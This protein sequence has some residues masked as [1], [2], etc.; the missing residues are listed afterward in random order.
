MFAE[1]L[2]EFKV[3][4]LDQTFT[5]KID[6]SLSSQIKEGMRVLVPFGRQKVEGFV[7]K[8]KETFE[9]EYEMKSILSCK[10]E[11]PVLNEELLKIG[12]YIS[13]TTLSTKISAYQTMLPTALKV[14]KDRTISKKYESYFTLTQPIHFILPLCKTETQR[15]IVHYVDEKGEAL[16]KELQQISSSSLKTLLKNGLLE[17]K[18]REVYRMNLISFDKKEKVKLTEKQKDVVT[19]I[20]KE[21]DF[22]PFLLHGITGS[23]KTEVYMELIEEVLK[24]GKQAIVLVPEISLTPQFLSKFRS[25]F[26]DKIAV[27]HSHLSN[28]EKYDEWRKIERGEVSIVI[29]ARSAIFAPFTNLG[30]IILD[31]EHSTSYKQMN[32]PRYHATDIALFRGKYHHCPVLLGS[33]TPSIESYTRAK[34]GIYTLLELKERVTG[35]LPSVTRIDMK[36]EMKQGHS[37]LSGSLVQKIEN[38]LQNRKQVLLL[39]NRRGYSTVNT[40]ASCGYVDKCPHCDIPLVFHKTSGVMRCHY[41]GYGKAKMKECPE[42][43]QSDF[44]FFGTGTQKLEEEVSKLFPFAKVLR[45]DRD[46]TS[47]K[48]AY[49]EIIR[50]FESREYDILVGTQM[51]AKGLDFKDVVLVGVL[52][53]DASLMVPDFRSGERTFCLLNQVAGRAGRSDQNGE[54]IMQGFNM[55]HYSIVKA[56]IHDYEGFYKEEMLLRKQMGYPPYY[57]LSMIEMKAKEY[58]LVW[59]ESKKIRTFL[60]KNTEHVFILGPTPATIAKMN[61]YFCFKIILKYKKKEDVMKSFWYLYEKYRSH[62]KIIVEIDVNPI[63]I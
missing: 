16:K 59:E 34:A 52:C 55:D 12:S 14:K 45:M 8:I 18:Q 35:K 63:Q 46:V 43:H 13:K 62:K 58:N 4:A 6:P 60:E 61:D 33:A 29:G 20:L 22:T 50:K 56:S 40:C 39:L 1:V 9:V 48:H 11:Y 37:F 21:T 31:E 54:V 3:A 51:I 36:D 53:A 5:Y 17:E 38:A 57:N 47:S 15:K 2:L 23:G 41:C 32:H 26:G 24:K 7:L 49:E 30:I 44:H 28:G 10:D 42:C 27:L 19:S 25:R